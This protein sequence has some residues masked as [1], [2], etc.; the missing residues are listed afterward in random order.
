MMDIRTMQDI[1]TVYTGYC[2][3]IVVGGAN[4]AAGEECPVR[5]LRGRGDA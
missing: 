3:G 2:E 4:S 1:E 5:S